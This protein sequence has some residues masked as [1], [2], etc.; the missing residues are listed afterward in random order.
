MTDISKSKLVGSYIVVVVGYLIVLAAMLLLVLQWG[1]TCDVSL[2]GKNVR[3]NTAVVA[4]IALGLGA[5]ALPFGKL[6]IGATL[7]IARYRRWKQFR[8]EGQDS[9]TV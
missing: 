3:A 9:P 2:Y 5:L 8:S 1:N 7:V 6:L 4:V